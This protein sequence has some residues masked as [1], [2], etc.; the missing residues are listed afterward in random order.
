MKIYLSEELSDSTKQLIR[1]MRTTFL[2]VM[3]LAT[4]LFATDLKS[5]VAKVTFTMKNTN[6][7]KVIDAIESQTDYLFVY[8]KNELDLNRKVSVDAENQSVAEVLTN[9]LLYTSPSPRD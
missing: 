4:A 6:I 9:C 5:Q 8:D 1:R 7:I 3:V 2:L